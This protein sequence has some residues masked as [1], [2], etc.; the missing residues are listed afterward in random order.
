[1]ASRRRPQP[2]QHHPAYFGE[3]EGRVDHLVSILVEYRS[4]TMENAHGMETTATNIK[5]EMLARAAAEVEGFWAASLLAPGLPV[6][7]TTRGWGGRRFDGEVKSL[8]SRVDPVT[9]TV[10]VRALLPNPEHALRPGMLMRVELL[11][12]RREA[13]VIPEQ[14]LVPLG[15]RQFVY[16]VDPAADNSVEHRE[17]RIGTRRP[18]EVEIVE[19][20]EAGVLETGLDEPPERPRGVV[21]DHSRPG[22]VPQR[23]DHR[24]GE[25]A[26]GRGQKLGRRLG[27][28]GR[29]DVGSIKARQQVH[30]VDLDSR[31][32]A[33]H[34]SDQVRH[35][36]RLDD[37]F[38]DLEQL[39][40]FFRIDF[41]GALQ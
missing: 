6:T 26:P 37:L 41:V 31:I 40:G 9:R 2:L 16:V 20:L 10:V 30:K 36:F 7:A 28:Q 39:T 32:L 3:G 33:T 14:C 27:F 19:G 24:A 38:N 35:H 22:E 1:M 5:H 17:V 4:L 29:I 15:D 34:T 21:G 11:Q 25:T 18:G 13:V 23:V 12:S 8:D